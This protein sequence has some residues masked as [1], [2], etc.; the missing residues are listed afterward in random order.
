VGPATLAEHFAGI[1]GADE[2]THRRVLRAFYAFLASRGVPADNARAWLTPQLERIQQREPDAPTLWPAAVAFLE[3][4]RN[5]RRLSPTTLKSYR[6]ALARFAAFVAGQGVTTWSA[7]EA[8]HVDR[9]LAANPR[10]ALAPFLA[11]LEELGE[12]PPLDVP[13][14][15]SG[16]QR[17]PR[18]LTVAEVRRLLESVR[19]ASPGTLRDRAALELLYASG[20]RVSELLGV[21]VDDVDLAAREVRVIGKGN[22]ERRVPFGSY[23]EAAVRTY[24]EHG[25]P[26][27][28]ESPRTRTL[29]VTWP[30]RPLT[31][32]A[33]AGMLRRRA[34]AAGLEHV[35]PHQLRHTCATH[36]LAGGADL[37]VVQEIL[38]HASILTTQLYTHLAP[39]QLVDAMR[40]HPR[41]VA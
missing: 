37:R 5:V 34:A 26:L 32:T 25:R 36:L 16:T 13:H 30:G 22:R 1:G 8:A 24:L 27:L 38:G 29:F 28:V 4:A 3:W 39:A 19:G 31:R 7:L 10:E 33:F 11:R 41:S 40:H 14:A 12:A 23:A 6:R 9:Y 17:L 35:H 2:R 15:G 18:V 20:L 21:E